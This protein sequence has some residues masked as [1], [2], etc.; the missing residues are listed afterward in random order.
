MPT[1]NS[2]G[3][4]YIEAER[5]DELR[6]GTP[7]ANEQAEASQERKA[8]G[9]GIAPGAT[10]VPGMGGRA[11]KGRTK[12]THDVPSALPVSDTL[13]RRARFARRKTCSELATFI[14]GGRCGILASLFVKLGVE[15]I[16]LREA[17]LERGDIEMAR[18]FG[19]SAR[20]HLLY[21]RE[22]AAKDAKS[23][24]A[25]IPGQLAALEAADAADER[26]MEAKRARERKALLEAGEDLGEDD[27]ETP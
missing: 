3:F 13:K 21:G 8:G 11:R 17:A 16:A 24:P 25:D 15:D 14:G 2:H 10:V 5:H 20:M 7:A 1:S 9:R 18:K 26:A 12:L 6:D 27:E 23:R 22:T 19:E 4:P